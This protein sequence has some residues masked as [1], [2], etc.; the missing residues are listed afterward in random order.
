MRDAEARLNAKR[1]EERQ[2]KLEH[3][4]QRITMNGTHPL[5]ALQGEDYVWGARDYVQIP[6]AL[7][8]GAMHALPADSYGYLC[9]KN[10]TELR[11]KVI[12]GISFAEDNDTISAASSFYDGLK[13]FDEFGIHCMDA[14]VYDLGEEYWNELFDIEYLT[15]GTGTYEWWG[16]L[17]NLAYNLG[18]MWTD[19]INYIYFTPDTVPDGDFGFFTVYLAGDFLM[20]IFVADRV[21]SNED[22]EDDTSN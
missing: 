8:I 3:A 16:V 10:T 17:E 20:R 1:A 9:S 4:M 12:E 11:Q 15:T 6:L 5:V 18:Y 13:L 14:F 2:V 22:D 7:L 19:V 21:P